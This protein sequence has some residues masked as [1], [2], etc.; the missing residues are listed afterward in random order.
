VFLGFVALSMEQEQGIGILIVTNNLKVF[1]LGIKSRP[2]S[3]FFG[4]TAPKHCDFV[5]ALT[6]LDPI[7]RKERITVV[8]T[9]GMMDQREIIE[10]L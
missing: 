7:K 10:I 4:S 9:M 1:R 5:D 2:D 6:K 8:A 3:M